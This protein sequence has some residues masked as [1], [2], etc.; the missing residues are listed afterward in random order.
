MEKYDK[1]DTKGLQSVRRDSCLVASELQETTLK[2]LFDLTKQNRVE[3]AVA[4]IKQTVSDLFQG[5]CDFD[6]LIITKALSKELDDAKINYNAAHVWL[7]LRKAALDPANKA[8]ATDRILYMAVMQMT[9]TVRGNVVKA[10]MC[11]EDPWTVLKY[12]LTI[13]VKWYLEKQLKNPVEHVMKYVIGEAGCKALW[14]GDH[15]RKIYKPTPIANPNNKNG[16]LGMGNIARWVKPTPQC[17]NRTCRT[18]LQSKEE[19]TRGL[20]KFCQPQLATIRAGLTAE[21][22]VADD[23]CKDLWE[24]C[25]KCQRGNMLLARACTTITC[26]TQSKRIRADEANGKLRKSLHEIA[27]DW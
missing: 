23:K 12:N 10:Y 21:L 25:R 19:Q 8:H 14:L 24:T 16:I 27:N 7:A 11:C 4:H 1:H 26:P 2:V 18:P 5:K 13:D 15:V 20:C 3:L 17:S 22:T 6:K 9:K